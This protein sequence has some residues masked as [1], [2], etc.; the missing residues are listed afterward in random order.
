MRTRT[1]TNRSGP[2]AGAGGPGGVLPGGVLPGG[3]RAGRVRAGGARAGGALAILATAFLMASMATPATAQESCDESAGTLGI[4]ALRCEGCTYSMS[5]EGIT[6]ARFRTEPQILAVWLGLPEGDRLRAGDRI[7]A[8]DG[9]LITTRAGSGRLV[10]LRA[11]QPITV[12]VRRNGRVMDLEMVAASA[13]DLNRRLDRAEAEVEVWDVEGGINPFELPPPPPADAPPAE[14]PLPPAPAMPAMPPSGYLGFGIK[15]GPC[16]IHDGVWYFD[17]NPPVITDVAENSPAGEAG[18][19]PEDVILAIDGNDITSAEGGER[20]SEIERGERV[21]L[22]IRRGNERQTVTLE[23]GE[24]L[25]RTPSAVTMPAPP[26]PRRWSVRPDTLA[27]D[28]PLTF[29][30]SPLYVRNEQGEV[31]IILRDAPIT[32]ERDD[33]TGE[34]VIR[35]GG[36][37]IRLSG[38]N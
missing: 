4:R 31:M 3:L 12:H 2:A 5:E 19:E 8:I 21:E 1:T 13:C 9:A 22:T 32:I 15:C 7:V 25:V 30:N 24:R 29:E 26:A 18:L 28:Q 10:D 14:A 17:E 36:R 16:G 20:F 37:V 33:A 11:G 23:A 6:E 38:G 27:F 34:I 35:S